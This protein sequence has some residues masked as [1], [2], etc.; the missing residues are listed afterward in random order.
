MD[1]ITQKIKHHFENKKYCKVTRATSQ[2]ST[3]KSSGFIVDYSDS[4]V[5]LQ[6]TNDFDFLGF[7]LLP[8]NQ[9]KEI[10]YNRTDKYFD[11]IFNW[12]GIKEKVGGRYEIDLSSWATVFKSLKKHSLIVI[13]ECENLDV[14]AFNIGPI[15]KITRDSVYIQ[16]FDATGLLDEKST[17]IDFENITRVQFDA[18][19]TNVFSKYLR[20]RKVKKLLT[21][22]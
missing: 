8:I 20:H 5:V 21:P 11:K 16:Y 22:K 3:E 13:V 2:S 6:E 19:Y 18:R 17:S 15:T 7:N 9:L 14:N 1:T 4:F 10:R 12:E